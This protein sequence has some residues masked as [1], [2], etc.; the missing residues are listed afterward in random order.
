VASLAVELH[1]SPNEILNWDSRMLAAVLQVMKE[2][3]EGVN[4][5][6]RGKRS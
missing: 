1:I 6:R 2:R 4:R 3:A 5:A